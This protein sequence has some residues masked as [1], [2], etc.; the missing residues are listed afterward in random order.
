MPNPEP[1]QTKNLDTYGNEA[2]PWSR[3]SA[4]LDGI[5]KSEH[6]TWFLGV[7]DPDGAP[8]ASGVGAM[9]SDGQLYFVSGPGTRKSRDLA[10]QPAASLSIGLDGIDLVF[11]GSARR[12]TDSATLQRIANE[13]RDDGGW[14]VE[15]T[16]GAFTAP[17]SAPSAGPPPWYLYELEYEAVYGVATA[18]PNGA[19]RWKFG[20][21]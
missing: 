3:A 14:P 2:L 1:N 13:Y 17:F 5:A 16:G 18:E 7:T 10:K 11:E 12:V 19:T 9:W 8:H 15:T 4:A 21:R 20:Q 6:T